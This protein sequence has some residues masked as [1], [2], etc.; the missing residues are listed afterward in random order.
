MTKKKIDG[1]VEIKL[2]RGQVDLL[3]KALEVYALNFR[4]FRTLEKDKKMQDF[5]NAVIFHTYEMLICHRGEYNASMD[6][7]KFY[8]S[9]RREIR[10][11]EKEKKEEKGK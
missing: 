1:K 10:K 11:K 9:I 2:Y 4:N 6:F 8:K 3:L 5:I 7:E